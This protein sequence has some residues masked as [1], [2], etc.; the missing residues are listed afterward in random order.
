MDIFEV[1]NKFEIKYDLVKHEPVYTC[2]QAQNINILI[3]GT[4]CKN[5][6][7]YDKKNFYLVILPDNKKADMKAIEKQIGSKRLSFC[8][9]TRL[10]DM[11]GLKPG[12]V[13]P[14]GII[15]DMENKVTLVIDKELQDKKLLFHPNTNTMTLNINYTDFIRFIENENHRYIFI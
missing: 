14:F 4:G 10:S 6:F 9:E 8:S 2:E 7:V 1:L 11:L 5:L 3:D 15:N 13:S 12:G